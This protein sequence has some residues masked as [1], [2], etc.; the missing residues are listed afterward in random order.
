MIETMVKE[1]GL[2]DILHDSDFD[3]ENWSSA[4]DFG[5]YSNSDFRDWRRY[6]PEFISNHWREL[7][8]ETRFCVFMMAQLELRSNPLP[9]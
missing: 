6:V 5:E 8:T 4:V 1:A 7:G 9:W 3:T 2:N